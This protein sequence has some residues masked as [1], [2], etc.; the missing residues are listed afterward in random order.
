MQPIRFL[1]IDN[2]SYY[3]QELKHQLERCLQQGA[4]IE[5]AIS[6]EAAEQRFLSFRPNILAVNFMM[7]NQHRNGKKYLPYLTERTHLPV[8]VFG[9]IEMGKSVALQDGAADY[10]LKPMERYQMEE[11]SKKLAKSVTNTVEKNASRKQTPPDFSANLPHTNPQSEQL[12]AKFIQNE[13]NIKKTSASSMPQPHPNSRIK[14][15]AIGSST[16]GTEALTV[17][18]TKLRPPMPP[19]VITQHIPATFSLLFASR[20]NADCILHVKEAADGDRPEP[21]TIYIAPGQL[22]MRV[23]REPTGAM[24]ISCQPGP[25]V[26]GC[27]PSV[28]VLFKSVAANIRDHAMGVILTGMGRDGA[29]GL[30]EMRKAGSPTIGQDEKTS[31]VYGM[32]RAAWEE[33]AVQEQFPLEKIAEAITKIIRN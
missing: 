17:V 5:F 10:I 1:I 32:P 11:F 22:H 19:I 15:I 31:T 12:K 27:C 28:D 14:L 30:L 24:R 7:L 20:L 8:I 3:H 26:H 9:S 25:R 23:L 16:G 33:G 18:L 4:A 21:N 6:P 13:S 2:T 29:D